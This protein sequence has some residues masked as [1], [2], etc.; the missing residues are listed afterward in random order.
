MGGHDHS[1]GM[2]MYYQGRAGGSSSAHL[3]RALATEGAEPSYHMEGQ[4]GQT[5][6]RWRKETGGWTEYGSEGAAAAEADT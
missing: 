4:K 2:C 3:V 6:A 5:P 1:F